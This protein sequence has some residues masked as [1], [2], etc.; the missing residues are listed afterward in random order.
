MNPS[1]PAVHFPMQDVDLDLNLAA[2]CD[3]SVLVTAEQGKARRDLA[4]FI[5]DHGLRSGGPFVFVEHGAPAHSD[6]TA[7]DDRHDFSVELRRRFEEARGGTLFIDDVAGLSAA[8]QAE[9]F[10]LLEDCS[11][12]TGGGHGEARAGGVRIVTGASRPMHAELAD[13][14]FSESLFYRLNLIHIDTI[15]SRA[16]D[17]PVVL[18][19]EVMST[20]AQACQTETD[21]A[22]VARVMWDHDC[23]IV[24]IVDPA[25]VLAGV[26]TDRDICIATAT[27]RLLPERIVAAQVMRAPVQTC[28]ADDAVGDALAVMKRFQVRRLPVVDTERRVQGVISLN[29]IVRSSQRTGEPCAAEIV[30]ALSAIG[31]H[32]STA[33]SV[34]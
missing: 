11:L 21:L 1:R 30:A 8:M 14:A 20:P 7:R 26:V 3:V 6:G 9:L 34:R 32:R 22:R 5:H 33:A 28:T 18:V 17:K 27:R 15:G 4:R 25:G 24:A 2:E 16:S 10:L 31:A 19:R 29:D 12:W 13:G 23:G